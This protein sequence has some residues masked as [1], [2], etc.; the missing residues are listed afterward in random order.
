MKFSVIIPTYNR[1]DKLKVAINSVFEQTYK[2]FEI[3]VVNDAGDDIQSVIDNYDKSFIKYIRLDNNRGLAN[4]RNVG[5]EYVTGNLVCF[6]DDDDNFLPNHFKIILDNIDNN[7]KIYYTDAYRSTY[8]YYNDDY[9]LISRYVPYSIDFDKNKLLIAN[10]SPFNCFVFFEELFKEHKFNPEFKVLEDWEFL[11]RLSQEHYFKH[12]KEITANV[13]LIIG[14]ESLT[15][16]KQEL[17]KKTR[18]KIYA[19]Y[20]NQIKEITNRQEIINYFNNIWQQ[21]FSPTFPL[22]SIIVLTYNN[23]KFTEQFL[24]SLQGSTNVI[25]ELIVVD[26]NSADGTRELLNNIKKNNPDIVKIILNNE[27]LGFPKAIN[28]ALKI[29]KGQYVLIAN[30]DIVVTQF[31]LE[32]MVKLAEKDKRNGIIGVLSNEVSGIQKV[33]VNYITLDQMKI[34]ADDISKRFKGQSIEFPRITFLCT[35]LKRELIEKLGALDERFSPGNFEDD[36]YC[37]RA[38]L[39]GYK[40]LVA[41]DVFIHHFGS[42]SFTSEGKN[43]YLDLL[44][45]NRQKFIEKWGADF[46]QIIFEKKEITPRNYYIPLLHDEV[47]ENFER[48][49]ILIDEGDYQEAARICYQTIKNW[50]TQ[51]EYPV[52][53]NDFEE[54]YELLQPYLKENN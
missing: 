7:S 52:S 19:E 21:D 5:L 18:D 37:I 48:I 25:F 44:E 40:C 4:A 8:K 47:L 10:I 23:R 12:I 46:N 24:A 2:N 30:N 43:K 26:N 41:K 39:A 54:L 17:F 6:L 3:I 13:N 38:L 53:K 34:F 9:W 27:N 29:A 36:D 28:Q 20:S 22:V 31:W 49:R 14:K 42:K 51:K 35:L 32:K 1:P 16:T 50:D 11:L 45:K 33:E 15:T